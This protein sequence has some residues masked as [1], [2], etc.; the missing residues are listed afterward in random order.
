[1]AR[2]QIYNLKQIPFFNSLA[3]LTRTLLMPRTGP[4]QLAENILALTCTIVTNYDDHYNS[5]A[6][7]LL[8]YSIIAHYYCC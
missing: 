4:M 3:P 6:L 5:V 8:N 2:I 1:M 7:L